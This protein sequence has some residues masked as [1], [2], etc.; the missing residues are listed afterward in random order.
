MSRQSEAAMRS[1]AARYA[2][3]FRA[4]G[5]TGGKARAKQLTLEQ[6]EAIARN[7]ARPRWAK[8]KKKS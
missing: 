7:A 5:A 4:W 6:R 8:A 1:L 3:L 2:K